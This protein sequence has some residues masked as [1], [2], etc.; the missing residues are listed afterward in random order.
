MAL[1]TYLIGPCSG[2]A[3]ILVDFNSSSLPAVNGNYYL[4]F[5]GATA[6]GCYDIITN[7][8]PSTGV[9]TVATMS[10]D[11]GDCATCLAANPTPTP[12]PTPTITPTK[13]VTPT[14]TPSSQT[15]TPTPTKTATPTITPTIT[16]TNT[17]TPSETPGLCKTYELYG[18]TQGTTFNFTDCDGNIK[19]ANVQPYTTIV[20]CATKVDVVSGNGSYVSIGTCPLP[21]PTTTPTPTITPTKTATPTITPTKT[22][23]P[24]IT[25]TK[26]ATPTITPTKTATPTKTPTPTT[27]KTPTVT[28][29]STIT[30]TVTATPT[31]TPTQTPTP[32]ITPT[33]TATP[34]I[35]PTKTAT[36]TITPTKTAT[37]T[38]TPT[39]TPTQY[40][41][42]GIGVDVQYEYTI[43]MLG[44]FSGGTAPAGEIAPHPIY[45]DGNGV[46]YAQLNAITLG[47]NNGLN[48]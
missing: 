46:P 33:K 17:P 10:T 31:K 2:G 28:P 15:P 18:G 25:P 23:T 6:P 35:T 36:P 3:S 12:T 21:T 5:N 40:P 14:I 7:A 39:P 11:Y 13:T 44:S 1:V 43:E 42:S 16:P 41:F 34:T 26:T 20:R 45:T 37:P 27:T 4:T 29:T 47:G 24:T 22:A 19:L 30:P 38:K 32:T 48:N 9:D 8:E